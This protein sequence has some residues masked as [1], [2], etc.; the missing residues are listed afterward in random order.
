MVAVEGLDLQ[1]PLRLRVMSHL[2]CY[3]AQRELSLKS[4]VSASGWNPSAFTT[5]MYP[6]LPSTQSTGMSSLSSLSS[7]SV[8]LHGTAAVSSQYTPNGS[9]FHQSLIDSSISGSQ[10][11]GHSSTYKTSTSMPSTSSSMPIGYQTSS[12]SSM[13]PM[14]STNAH[15][16]Y[17]PY[18]SSAY[19]SASA[20]NGSGL[21]SQHNSKH[22][23]PWGA[24]LAF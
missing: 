16:L 4:N 1:D 7:D 8:P 13:T 21:M 3:S 22:Y 24:E 9:H 6:S 12:S 10:M 11:M 2:Q 5:P 17:N 19:M 20:G 14:S 23:R 18:L 15:N